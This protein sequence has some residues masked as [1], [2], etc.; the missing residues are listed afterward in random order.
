MYK[1][2]RLEWPNANTATCK[3]KMC[4]SKKGMKIRKMN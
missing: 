1:Y 4:K 3:I 2:Y